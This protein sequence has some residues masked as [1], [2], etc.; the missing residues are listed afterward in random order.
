MKRG[1]WVESFIEGGEK[2]VWSRVK[3]EK[4]MNDCEQELVAKKL[5][6]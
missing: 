4:R 6:V 1:W 3:G 2:R 5:E